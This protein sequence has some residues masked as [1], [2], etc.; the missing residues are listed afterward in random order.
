MIRFIRT[1]ITCLFLAL[2]VAGYGSAQTSVNG[3]FDVMASP[4]NAACNGTADDTTALNAAITAAGQHG[5]IRIPSG[6]TCKTSGITLSC[7]NKLKA[8]GARLIPQAAN[9]TVLTIKPDTQ[10]GLQSNRQGII[11]GL[12]ID[13]SSQT[14][15]TGLHMNN[16]SHENVSNVFIH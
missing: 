15:T 4:Y 7:M 9:Q 11:D 2:L 8:T 1:S 10:C 14:G 3:E 16:V 5:T 13:G 6:R 12:R